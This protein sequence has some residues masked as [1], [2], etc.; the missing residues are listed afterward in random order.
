MN[1]QA[2]PI[3]IGKYRY[4]LLGASILTFLLIVMG[5]IVRVTDSGLGCPDWPTCYGQ[6]IPPA[7]LDS[8]IEYLHRFI[9]ALTTPFILSSA[10]VGWWKYRSIRWISRPPIFALGFLV[11]EITLGAITVLHE[12]PPE[13]VAIHLFGSDG[14]VGSI[15]SGFVDFPQRYAEADVPV[16]PAF[17]VKSLCSC[18]FESWNRGCECDIGGLVDL[19]EG[20]SG[21]QVRDFQGRSRRLVRG[22]IQLLKHSGY[23]EEVQ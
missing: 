15:K 17:V 21:P 5:G 11:I 13:I 23:C 7:R 14:I 22:S 19:L 2:S 8:W 12:L 3:I 6:L 1:K 9:A 16:C 4:L 10:I 20:H 18:F